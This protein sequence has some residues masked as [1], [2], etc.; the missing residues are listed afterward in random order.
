MCGEP[1]DPANQTIL[2]FRG[3]YGSFVDGTQRV[4]TKAYFRCELGNG[5]RIIHHPS[6]CQAN[7]EWTQTAGCEGS[8]F[9]GSYLNW[10]KSISMSRSSS[11]S[12]S[13]EIT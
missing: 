7:G 11:R 3:I 8:T 4:G 6:V 1:T 10:V 9:T 12:S 13:M 5:S 2:T